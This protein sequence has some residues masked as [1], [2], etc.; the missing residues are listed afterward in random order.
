Q[1]GLFD[2]LS[3]G[4]LSAK[5]LASST[6][7]YGPAVQA[8]ASAAESYGFVTKSDGKLELAPQVAELLLDR[9]HPEYLGGQIA[10]LALRSLEFG[11]LAGLFK[12]GATHPIVSNFEAIEEA[13]HWDHFAFLNAIRRN[14]SLDLLL[15]KGCRFLDVGCGTGTLIAKL[16][17]EY[18]RTNFVG[19]DASRKAIGQARK[20][21]G[22]KTFRLMKAEAMAFSNE[23]DIAYLGESL[24]SAQ[25]KQKATDNCFRALKKNGIIAVI[26]GLLPTSEIRADENKL[27]MGM[28]LDFALQGH[29][30]LTSKEIQSI[31]KKSG[32]R[33]VRLKALGGAVY[34]ITARK[35]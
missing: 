31:L 18:P 32:F 25:N 14:K 21:L 2:R 26:E 33:S 34:L 16:L 35:Q 23:F 9:S 13:T 3:K 6:G 19:I 1:T 20:L 4:T 8:W 28:Q 11:K 7:L 12:Q 22:A 29:R 27:I 24:Y 15:R 30:F 5:D 17:N 10:Y